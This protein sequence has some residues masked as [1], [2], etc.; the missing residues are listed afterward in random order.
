MTPIISI[1]VPVYN[2]EKFIE[3]T[4][5]SLTSQSF[6]PI[7]II[8]CDNA[9]TDKTPDI[10]R[11]Y[12]KDHPNIKYFREEVNRGSLHNY[13]KAFHL[14]DSKYF[15]WAGGHDLWSENFIE[16]AT[17]E[18]ESHPEAALAFA[19]TVWIDEN[20]VTSSRQSGWCDTRGMHPIERFLVTILGNVHPVLGIMRSDYLTTAPFVNVAGTDLILLCDLS[21]KGNFLHIPNA[22]CYRR[23][24]ETRID[25]SYSERMNRYRNKDFKLSTSNFGKIFPL[26]HLPVELLRIIIQSQLKPFEKVQLLIVALPTFLVKYLIARNKVVYKCE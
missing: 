12:L 16:E 17:N 4:L 3:R 10:I 19:T 8:I 22:T 24:L 2:E 5:Q 11:S 26:F 13:I 14:S 6:Q 9:S 7:E 18:L 1:G 23:E 21:L 20:C 15:M 25:E